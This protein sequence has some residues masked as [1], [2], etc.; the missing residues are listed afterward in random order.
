MKKTAFR[1]RLMAAACRTPF[2]VIVLFSVIPFNTRAQ[3]SYRQSDI[4]SGAILFSA[5]CSSCHGAG[6]G[7]PGIDLRM[8]QFRHANSDSDLLTVIRNGIRGTAMPAHDD[9]T[10][11]ETVSLVAYIRNMRDYNEQAVKPGDLQKGKFLFEGDGG[12]L[13]CH[14]VNGKGSR[15][16]LDLSDTGTLHPAAYLERALRDP[17]ANADSQ[18]QNGFLTAITNQGKVITGRRLNEDTFTIQ[19]IDQHENLVSLEKSNLKSLTKVPG[20]EMHSLRGKL[21]SDQIS[22][23]VAYLAS[24]QVAQKTTSSVPAVGPAV[25]NGTK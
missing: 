9:L 8:G 19:L 22:D 25:S 10:G 5:Q 11:N 14:R 20:V 17:K 6:D 1:Y 23:L 4:D 24:L 18:P 3:Q 7:V 13:D 16:A 2:S 21:T 12:C 15:F